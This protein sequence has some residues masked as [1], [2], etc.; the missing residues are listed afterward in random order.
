MEMITFI[1]LVIFLV[2][3]LI[4]MNQ[5]NQLDRLLQY[6]SN[7]KRIAKSISISQWSFMII[8]CCLGVLLGYV[9][10]TNYL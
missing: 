7:Y 9:I 6:N 8:G 4:G 1:L 10:T 5:C 2:C 3:G